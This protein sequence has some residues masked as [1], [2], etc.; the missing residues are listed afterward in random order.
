MRVPTMRTLC[1]DLRAARGSRAGASAAPL[2]LL[3]NPLVIL[4]KSV[5]PQ[6]WCRSLK[7]PMVEPVIEATRIPLVRTFGASPLSTG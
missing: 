3:Q 2:N 7:P 1:A 6:L 5:L 4:T